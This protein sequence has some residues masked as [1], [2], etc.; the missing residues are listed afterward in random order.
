MRQQ[1][2]VRQNLL[3]CIGYTPYC[4]N[5]LTLNAVGGCSNPRTHWFGEIGQF[6][7]HECG[8]VSSFDEE[9]INEYKKKWN[10]KN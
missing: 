9:F 3:N 4:G 2:I 10:L 5:S 1:S 8:W 6:I 7:C